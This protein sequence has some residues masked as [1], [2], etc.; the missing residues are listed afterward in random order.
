MEPYG[1]SKFFFDLF[2]F[3][4]SPCY[5]MVILF[6]WGLDD[7]TFDDSFLCRAIRDP[8]ESYHWLWKMLLVSSKRFSFAFLP[9][10][11]YII[12][13]CLRLFSD[14]HSFISQTPSR[15]FLL[16]VSYIEIYN[17]VCVSVDVIFLVNET[18]V[19]LIML[20]FSSIS[21]TLLKSSIIE[22]VT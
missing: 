21:L 2:L 8:L 6:F 17:E 11:V 10:K 15:E 18:C 9:E 19:R 22:L 16:R 7:T 3:V 12:F 13:C 5:C 4:D 20:T 1:I 14:I